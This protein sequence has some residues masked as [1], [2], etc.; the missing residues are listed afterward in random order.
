MLIKTINSNNI[1]LMFGFLMVFTIEAS[2]AKPE[3]Q[4]A[5]LPALTAH[6]PY[7]GIKQRAQ[8]FDISQNDEQRKYLEERWDRD[9][10]MISSYSEAI[11]IFNNEMINAILLRNNRKIEIDQRNEGL[12]FEMEEDFEELN[13]LF[14]P[15]KYYRKFK[16]LIEDKQ[17][18]INKNGIKYCFLS[19]WKIE[20]IV[21][22]LFKTC[23][24][25]EAQ[26]E[27]KTQT[28]KASKQLM[29]EWLRK[30]QEKSFRKNYR[31]KYD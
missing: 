13:R 9:K 16:K 5:P 4:S 15:S 3:I 17:K 31:K 8:S 19:L 6:S 24:I 22:E 21:D 10:K 27:A 30:L 28:A 11:G 7:Y 20:T 23:N 12:M 29:K 2:E 25:N 14:D 18:E 1:I 26:A